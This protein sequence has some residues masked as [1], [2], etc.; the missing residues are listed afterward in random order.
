[1]RIPFGFFS[2]SLLVLMLPGLGPRV[3]SAA[4]VGVWHFN[5]TSGPIL[6][7]SGNDFHGTFTGGA[8]QYGH[9]SPFGTALRFDG[10]S[11]VNVGNPFDL[12]DRS[13]SIE[14]WVNQDPGPTG[15]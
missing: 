4:L 14:M 13:F 12:N 10:S 8:A 5:E 9:P 7:V 15:N 6:D 2:A 11:H 3:A 1:M